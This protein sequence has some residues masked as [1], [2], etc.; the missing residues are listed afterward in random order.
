VKNDSVK[1]PIS[2][3][4]CVL[5][6]PLDG[7]VVHTHRVLTMPGGRDVT[8]EELEERAK[9]RAKRAGHDIKG[10]STL[11]VTSDVCDCSSQYR[12]DLA[13][14]KLQKLE[15]RPHRAHPPSR[16]LRG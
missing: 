14:K 13:T 16:R 9:D 10:L 5:Y 12:V 15:R 4:I 2:D 6:D 8:D 7:R 3:K 11:R 1:K